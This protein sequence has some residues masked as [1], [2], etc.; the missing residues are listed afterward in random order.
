MCYKAA[1]QCPA[2]FLPQQRRI[3]LRGGVNDLPLRDEM[4]N[5]TDAVASQGR[6][7]TAA[8]LL[9]TAL[10]GTAA[11]PAMAE[12]LTIK[13]ISIGSAD[14]LLVEIP[15]IEVVDGNIEEATIRTLFSSD[16]SMGLK[17]L[18]ELDAKSLSIPTLKFSVNAPGPDGTPVATVAT[19]SGLQLEDV[20][21]GV[22]GSLVLEATD[23][24]GAQG[25]TAHFGRASSGRFDLGGM[26]GLYGLVP[27]AGSTEIEPIYENFVFEGGTLS[28]AMFQ[29]SIGE[30]RVGSFSAR[31]LN[32]G[33]DQLIKASTDLAAAEKANAQPSAESIT[34]MVRFYADLLTAFTSD[35]QTIAGFNCTGTDPT[36]GAVAVSSGPFTVGG[37]EP[38]VY[39]AFSLDGLRVDVADKGWLTLGNFTWKKMDFNAAIAEVMGAASIDVDWL[40]ANARKLVPAM[41][42]LSAANLSFDLP[43][44]SN[45]GKRIEASLGGLDVTA[46]KYINGIPSDLSFAIN[47]LEMPMPPEA[48][49]PGPLLIANGITRLN[50]SAG[51]GVHWDEASQTIVIDDISIESPKLGFLHLSATLGNATA[52]LFGDNADA[53][54]AASLGLTLKSLSIDLEDRGLG[55]ILFAAGARDSGQPEPAFRTAATGMAQGM[56]LAVLGNTD[57][58]LKAAQALGQFVSGQP[59]LSMTLTATDPAGISLMELQ[60]ASENPTLLTGKLDVVAESSGEPLPPATAPAME[61]PAT[62]APSL[63]MQAPADTSSEDGT[64]GAEPSEGSVEQQKLDLKAGGN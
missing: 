52:D 2:F 34:T 14:T 7:L 13:D 26:L 8:L 23:V 38:G 35:Q 12:T 61:A 28:A 6:R 64:Q 5:K 15:S 47:A 33:L 49:G 19:Y 37:F 20:T 54:M 45:P 9:G 30:S 62:E 40:M 51:A 39:P 42:G 18:S 59:K 50:L 17:A 32:Y 46:G 4:T 11:L 56:L 48:D 22:A 41:E 36:G 29:C 58:A 55:P 24:T 3:W 1:G 44:E 25:L 53:A 60:A 63:E 31:S 10:A 43:D 21:D 16:P 57:S 27:G